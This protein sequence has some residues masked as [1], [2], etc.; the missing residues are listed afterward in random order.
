MEHTVSEAG[1]KAIEAVIYSTGFHTWA[2]E[3]VA[4]PA[5][6]ERIVAMTA[7]I[8]VRDGKPEE[9]RRF[10]SLASHVLKGTRIYA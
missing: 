4:R 3:F 6:R 1:I 10:L 2:K 9:S 5:D 8:L 7:R